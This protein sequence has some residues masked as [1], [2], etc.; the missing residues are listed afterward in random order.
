MVIMVIKYSNLKGI[1]KR[2]TICYK[3][4]RFF[5]TKNTLDSQSIE[6]YNNESHFIKDRA[7]LS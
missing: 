1:T 5:D 3:K 4:N 7:R 6:R 2:Q